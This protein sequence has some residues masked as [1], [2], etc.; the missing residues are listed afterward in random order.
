MPAMN[1]PNPCPSRPSAPLRAPEALSSREPDTPA[2]A[3]TRPSQLLQW[4]PSGLLGGTF[5]CTRCAAQAWQP[6]L[7]VHGTDCAYRASA[8]PPGAAA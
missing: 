7:L 6:D 1:P 4:E 2:L 5:T 3:C 8:Q